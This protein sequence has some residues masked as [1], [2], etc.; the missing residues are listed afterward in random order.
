MIQDQELFNQGL[1]MKIFMLL[2]TLSGL[3]GC[4]N[5]ITDKKENAGAESL[6]SDESSVTVKHVNKRTGESK[7]YDKANFKEIAKFVSRL[8]SLGEPV[9]IHLDENEMEKLFNQNEYLEISFGKPLILAQGSSGIAKFVYFLSGNYGNSPTGNIGYFFIATDDG[10]FIQSPFAVQ[11]NI[12]NE[13]EKNLIE[14]P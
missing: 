5:R 4:C 2:I 7:E 14:R 12:I 9:R 10:Q 13:I 6:G 11:R 8:V 1:F 3:L